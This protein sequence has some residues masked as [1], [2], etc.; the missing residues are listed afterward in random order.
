MT[1]HGVLVLNRTGSTVINSLSL[2]LRHEPPYRPWPL[3]C[4]SLVSVFSDPVL[5]KS[6]T[7][8]VNLYKT[9]LLPRVLVGPCLY[10]DQTD[11]TLFMNLISWSITIPSSV[12]GLSFVEMYTL[13]HYIS[14]NYTNSSKS[15]PTYFGFMIRTVNVVPTNGR[16]I[17]EGT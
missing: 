16:R 14:H 9:L 8:V 12:P 10:N 3:T 15:W 7:L 2:S 1:T 5:I 11:L 13:L 17:K 4:Y 6:I